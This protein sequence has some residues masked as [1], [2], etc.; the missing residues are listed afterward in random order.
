[1]ASGRAATSKH[2]LSFQVTGF[3]GEEVAWRSA[4][5]L[6]SRSGDVLS[7][8][9]FESVSKVGPVT[10]PVSFQQIAGSFA[11][12]PPVPGVGPGALADPKPF[13]G[14]LAAAG[15]RALVDTE[16]LGFDFEDFGSA[17][18]VLAGVTAAQLAPARRQEAKDAVF[19]AMY[20][21]GDGPRHFRNVTQ[22]IIG[23]RQAVSS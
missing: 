14:Q 4:S 18:E 20:P 23:E 22:F 19:V 7:A 3:L 21:E 15:I 5:D 17:W 8:N 6:R 10:P 12:P 1:M 16:T 13:L 11:P 9:T 2:S